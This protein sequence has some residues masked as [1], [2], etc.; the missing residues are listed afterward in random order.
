MLS[1]WKCS[2]CLEKVGLGSSTNETPPMQTW[3]TKWIQYV[4][5]MFRE[6]LHKSHSTPEEVSH[7]G[8]KRWT[9]LISAFSLIQV[10][11]CIMLHFETAGITSA[12]TRENIYTGSY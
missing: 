2:T 1:N 12:G 5:P 4:I 7:H 8:V 9:I 3:C 6:G 10:I 11:E